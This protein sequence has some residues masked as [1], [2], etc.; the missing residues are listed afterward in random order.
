MESEI[1]TRSLYQIEMRQGENKYEN[2]GRRER[3]G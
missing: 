2:E 3:E 1:I